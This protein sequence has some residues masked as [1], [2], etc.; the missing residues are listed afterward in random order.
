MIDN[1]AS[2]FNGE[3]KF[4]VFSQMNCSTLVIAYWS[5]NAWHKF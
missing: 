1:P 2:F 3:D 5:M 4:P